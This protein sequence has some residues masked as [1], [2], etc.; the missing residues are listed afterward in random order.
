MAQGIGTLTC[1]LFVFGAF[2]GFFKLVD[3]VVG[4]RVSA[5]V[6][7][8]GLDVPEVGSLAYPELGVSPISDAS[9]MS[10]QAAATH[11]AQPQSLSPASENA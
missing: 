3:A 4:N 11:T 10:A 7:R 5:E 6:E 2:Y 1:G 8:E 9:G